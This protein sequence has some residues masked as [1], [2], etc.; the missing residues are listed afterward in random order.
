M[1]GEKEEFN[2]GKIVQNAAL[3]VKASD[4]YS[5]KTINLEVYIQ[6]PIVDF[7]IHT[8]PV[9]RIILNKSD[10]SFYSSWIYS[11]FL[12][13]TDDKGHEITFFLKLD[14]NATSPFFIVNYRDGSA[15]KFQQE[16]TN[17]STTFD[18]YF[19]YSGIYK[20][21][22]TVLNKVSRIS[23]IIQVF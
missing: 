1:T 11:R 3:S 10:I 23:K 4:Q 15:V 5:T 6:N 9:N 2:S 20:V 13:F 22:I 18:H 19:K 7:E 16:I 17:G 14:H 21:N 8:N 12:F